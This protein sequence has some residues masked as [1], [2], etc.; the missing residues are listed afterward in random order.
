[1]PPCWCHMRRKTPSEFIRVFLLIAF[2]DTFQASLALLDIAAFLHTP[3]HVPNALR[4]VA[5]D[6]ERAKGLRLISL[7]KILHITSFS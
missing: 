3:H 2:K 6:A 7:I 1:M 4:L 5:S